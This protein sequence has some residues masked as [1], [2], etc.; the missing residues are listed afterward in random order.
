MLTEPP[1]CPSVSGE[2]KKFVTSGAPAGSTVTGTA[3]VARP[4][5]A[6]TWPAMSDGVALYAISRPMRLICPISLP[7][8]QVG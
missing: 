2:T 1:L 5:V 3:S 4:A 8:V 7:T 6:I